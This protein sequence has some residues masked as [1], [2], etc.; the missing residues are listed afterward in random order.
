MGAII[1]EIREKMAKFSGAR[2]QHDA[3]SITYFSDNPNGFV[4]RLVVLKESPNNECYSVYFNGSHEEFDRR[5]AAIR[6][7]GFGLS[8]LCRLR[9]FTRGGEPYRWIVDI[10]DDLQLKWKPD[11]EIVRVSA[12]FWQFWRSPTVRYLQNHLI[13]LSTGSD[14]EATAGVLIPAPPGGGLPSLSAAKEIPREKN[15]S[16]EHLDGFDPPPAPCS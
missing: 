3:S 10:K 12:A 16:N 7:F 6:A 9:E 5:A 13:D 15:P 11:W 1:D 14:P 2:V 8:T 4:V